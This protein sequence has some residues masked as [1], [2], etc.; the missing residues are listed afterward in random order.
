MVNDC[1]LSDLV[2]PR[3]ALFKD[4]PEHVA[5][6]GFLGRGKKSQR[7]MRVRQLKI[8]EREEFATQARRAN[9]DFS[10]SEEW[11]IVC[12]NLDCALVG[13]NITNKEGTPGEGGENRE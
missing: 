10:F 4:I 5:K 1:Y 2:L 12:K 7:R 8:Q 9:V 11:L 13:Q 3:N 6:I